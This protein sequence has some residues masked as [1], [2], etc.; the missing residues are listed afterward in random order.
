MQQQ[1]H[2]LTETQAEN[3]RRRIYHQSLIG[4]LPD[5][6]SIVLLERLITDSRMKNVWTALDRRVTH[7]RKLEHFFSA[8]ES[9]ITGWRGDQKQT[10][11]ER[12]AFYQDILDTAARLQSLIDS[13]S[14]FDSY[15][16]IEGLIESLRATFP[17]NVAAGEE[18]S[19]TRL[20]LSNVNPST[21]E[22][23]NDIAEIAKQYRDVPPRVKKPNSPNAKIHYFIRHLSGYC[24]RAYSQ[25][26]HE[27]V[28]TTTSVGFDLADG[29][30]FTV[31]YVRKLVKS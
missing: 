16:N 12:R 20:C 5:K 13:A 27:V 11:A 22:V 7:E 23:L 26:L 8:C 4:A 17:D 15:S 25:P 2:K 9:G 6:E 19:Y 29:E 30:E 3:I 18:T 21:S 24:L 31:D 28:A 14:G 10:A 1:G